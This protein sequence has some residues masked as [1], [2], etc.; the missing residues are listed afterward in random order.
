MRRAAEKQALQVQREAAL[1]D[2]PIRLEP[3]S[4]D[5]SSLDGRRVIGEGTFDDSRTVFLDNRTRGG[6]AG[7]HVVTPLRLGSSAT[8]V[9]VL[10]GWIAR[11]TADRTRLPPL[12]KLPGPVR[13]EGLAMASLAQPMLLGADAAPA[14]G[15]LIW[16][17]LTLQRYREWSSLA[18][19]PVI[20]RQT[21]ELDDGLVREWAQPGSDVDKHRGYAFQWYAM[22]AVT[23]GLWVV[24]G[25]L[26]PRGRQSND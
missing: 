20:V 17:H 4:L 19:L 12:R 5:A 18:V 25:C 21:S 22:A 9:L 24:F 23:A 16:Q 8:H 3:A 10:R 7:F 2:V 26:R 11:D 15:E 14:Q 1:S 6:V 13:V